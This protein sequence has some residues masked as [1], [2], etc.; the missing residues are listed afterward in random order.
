MELIKE[1]KEIIQE[2]EHKPVDEIK[3]DDPKKVALESIQQIRDVALKKLNEADI[4]AK[5]VEDKNVDLAKQE[6]AKQAV[7][8][9]I[10][11]N[12]IQ[13]KVAAIDKNKV[14]ETLPNEK[15]Q[16]DQN[17]PQSEAQHIIAKDTN[18][19][20]N[21]KDIDV[22]PKHSPDEPN[23]YKQ[24][25]N[26]QQQNIK[27]PSKETILPIALSLN[28][29][30]QVKTAQNLQENN[31]NSKLKKETNVINEIKQDTVVREKRE[32]LDS[33][34][35][36]PANKDICNNNLPQDLNAVVLKNVDLNDAIVRN[37][38][39]TAVVGRSL[40]SISEKEE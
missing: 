24:E 25:E 23:S 12:E 30:T 13:E 17:L 31:D 4:S 2:L 26:M 7:E 8:S 3:N 40:K 1:Q 22:I 34:E 35:P 6:I 15:V 19:E 16:Y 27:A 10:A 9:I 28:E 38:M 21:K 29:N 37:V 36:C 33:H 18:P 39:D 32:L 20:T 14:V 5:G 11:I